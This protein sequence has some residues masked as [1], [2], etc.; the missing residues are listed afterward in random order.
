M[1]L[2]ID[3][4]PDQTA[5]RHQKY[6]TES[7]RAVERSEF[8][9]RVEENRDRTDDSQDHVDDE[10]MPNRTPRLHD[11]QALP[12]RVEQQQGHQPGARNSQ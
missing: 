4:P 12:Q 8:E 2:R 5:R 3:D 10:P 9:V 11:A 1:D 7:H 6:T